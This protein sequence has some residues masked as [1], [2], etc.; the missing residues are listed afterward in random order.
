MHMAQLMPL[1]LTALCVCV[2]CTGSPAA[3]SSP[4]KGPL[5]G[6]YVCVCA[7]LVS[8]CVCRGDV[9]WSVLGGRSEGTT[10]AKVSKNHS[11]P[12]LT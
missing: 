11:S 9:S 1:P 5:Y 2:S 3:V 12:D 6:A 10:S 4:G 7:S 8:V